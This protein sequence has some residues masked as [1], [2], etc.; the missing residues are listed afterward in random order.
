MIIE[1]KIDTQKNINWIKNND[2]EFFQNKYQTL[3][4]EHDIRIILGELYDKGI[5][6]NNYQE[7]VEKYGIKKYDFDLP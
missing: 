5:M 4:N 7:Q 1:L 3:E 6:N 2:Y